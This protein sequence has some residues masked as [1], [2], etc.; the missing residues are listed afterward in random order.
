MRARNSRC[1][2][3]GAVRRDSSRLII[4]QFN[5]AGFIIPIFN[6]ATLRGIY[7]VRRSNCDLGVLIDTS[8]QSSFA[9]PIADAILYDTQAVNPEIAKSQLSCSYD[10]ILEGLWHFLKRNLMKVTFQVGRES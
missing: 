5:T 1:N 6:E 2:V 10:G 4:W 7:G 3:K 8:H 9:D